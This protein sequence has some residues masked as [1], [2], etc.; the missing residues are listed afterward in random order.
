MTKES[1]DKFYAAAVMLA[2][3]KEKKAEAEE[4]I[5]G[6]E[7]VLKD[8]M[9][10]EN[11]ISATVQDYTVEIVKVGSTKVVDTA[12]LKKDGLFDQY[13]KDRAGFE[14]VKITNPNNEFLAGL[15]ERRK[16]HIE[17]SKK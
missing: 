12:K 5:K 2:A 10:A 11:V 6:A 3:A 14:Q 17:E 13:S 4:A 1:E 9:A 15:E 16:K 8:V 7:K